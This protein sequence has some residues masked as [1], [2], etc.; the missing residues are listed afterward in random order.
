MGAAAEFGNGPAAP[1]VG[2]GRWR[3]HRAAAAEYR[4]LMS[5]FPTGV[6]IVTAIDIDGHPHG[7]TCTSLSSVTLEPPTLL[8]CLDIRSGTLEAMRGTGDFALNLLG[9]GGR[10][11]AELF[12]SP[13]RD[14]FERV[15]WRP[16]RFTGVPWL[17]NDALAV[18]ECSVTDV[19]KVGDHA[20]VVGEVINTEHRPGAPLLYGLR[21]FSAW[22]A[23]ETSE[24]SR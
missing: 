9:A 17:F 24:G 1:A 14:R 13:V 10:P 19:F 8:V 11:V 2:L 12:S 4:T 21:R 20:V 7:M 16:S 6:A 3:P 23:D 15:P 22:T 5:C 18:A